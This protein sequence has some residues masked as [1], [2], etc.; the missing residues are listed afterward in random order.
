[1]AETAELK[2]EIAGTN[3]PR[4]DVQ[5]E[6]EV[7]DEVSL[8]VRVNGDSCLTGSIEFNDP[9]LV[10]CELSGGIENGEWQFPYNVGVRAETWAICGFLAC[11]CFVSDHACG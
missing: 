4:V 3:K 2:F 8:G 1:M 10:T 9:S 11:V 5:A 6:F 7:S